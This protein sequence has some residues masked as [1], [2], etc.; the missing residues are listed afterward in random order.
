MT[1]LQRIKPQRQKWINQPATTKMDPF[2]F[3]AEDFGVAEDE[4]LPFEITAETPAIH[5]TPRKKAKTVSMAPAAVAMRKRKR[6]LAQNRKNQQPF[7]VRQKA[8]LNDLLPFFLDDEK[9]L[10]MLELATE[11][12][13][14]KLSFRL[15]NHVLVKYVNKRPAQYL[16][17]PGRPGIIE[18]GDPD[19]VYQSGDLW[20]TVRTNHKTKLRAHRKRLTDC[21]RRHREFLLKGVKTTLCQLNFQIY[22]HKIRLREYMLRH[23]DDMREDMRLTNIQ[24]AA[25]KLAKKSGGVINSL[26]AKRLSKTPLE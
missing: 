17:R 5:A 3:S 16:I 7:T 20:I 10:G 13:D 8:L 9:H 14:G 22:Q 18:P 19:F 23:V 12:K 1:N 15:Y 11:G 4:K 24:E 2:A 26:T 25:A 21:F 6:I